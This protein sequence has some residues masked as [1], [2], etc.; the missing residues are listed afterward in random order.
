MYEHFAPIWGSPPHEGVIALYEKWAAGGWGI[1]MTGN[2][3]V[4]KDHLPLGRDLIVP[5]V[6][7]DETLAPWRRLADTIHR[8][9]PALSHSSAGLKHEESRPLAIMQLSHGGRQSLN[10]YSGR[11]LFAPPL[12]PSPVRVGQMHGG[13]DGWLSRLAHWLLLQVPKEM[14]HDDIRRAIQQFV[15]GAQLAAQS[16][17]DGIE[18]HAAHGCKQLRADFS[19]SALTTS[20]QI[21]LVSSF[22]RRCV[23]VLVLWWIS[24]HFKAFRLIVGRTSILRIGIPSAS[25]GKLLKQSGHPA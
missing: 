9:A 25:F 22:H 18:L 6:L 4:A 1:V 24:S 15:F 13:K 10:F 19:S 5:D 12:A 17:F 16:G 21:C 8:G 11:P 7:T 20:R 14:T 3:Q 23:V 2:V